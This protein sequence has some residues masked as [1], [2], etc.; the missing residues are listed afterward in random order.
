MH[1]WIIIVSESIF[2]IFPRRAEQGTW[3]RC[4]GR[5]GWLFW[6]C[7]APILGGERKGRKRQKFKSKMPFSKSIEFDDVALNTYPWVSVWVVGHSA[8]HLPKVRP[9]VSRSWL[10]FLSLVLS[11]RAWESTMLSRYGEPYGKC[12]VLKM[13]IRH[14]TSQHSISK[15]SRS[16][17]PFPPLVQFECG[18]CCWKRRKG[19][20][21]KFTEWDWWLVVSFWPPR[22]LWK[23][24][25]T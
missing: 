21:T 13:T 20:R 22:T 17:L 2:H 25:G 9:S 11:V 3:L 6:C 15:V 4:L 8:L 10:P 16:A 24:C 18:L 23:V 7:G 1:R 14:C 12:V 5:A 19:K